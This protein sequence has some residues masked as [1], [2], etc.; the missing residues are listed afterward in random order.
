MYINRHC[1]YIIMIIEKKNTNKQNYDCGKLF[2]IIYINIKTKYRQQM[3]CLPVFI[4]VV[5]FNQT[6]YINNSQL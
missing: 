1:T 2:Y 6:F 5:L 3:T 4:V